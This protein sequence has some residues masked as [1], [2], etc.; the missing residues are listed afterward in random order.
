MAR[1]CALLVGVTLALTACGGAADAPEQEG[2]RGTPEGTARVFS[3]TPRVPLDRPVLRVSSEPSLTIGGGD[4]ESSGVELFRVSDALRLADGRIV[5]ANLGTSEVLVLAPDGRLLRRLGRV[6]G[7]PGEFDANSAIFLAAAGDTLF[8]TDLLR[9][10]FHAFRLDDTTAVPVTVSLAPVPGLP[11]PSVVDRFDDGSWLALAS[12]GGTHGGAPGTV[13]RNTL[14]VLRFGADGAF[15]DTIGTVPV[16]PQI[17]VVH[18]AGT[19]FPLLPLGAEGMA[20]GRGS[21]AVL[22]PGDTALVTTV[23]V[24]TAGRRESSWGRPAVRSADVWPAYREQ[25]RREIA[26]SPSV[27]TRSVY[28]ALYDMD[29]LP[30]PERAA[31]FDEAHVDATGRLW[32]RRVTY[33]D[34]GTDAYRRWDVLAA[35]GTWLGEALVPAGLR[36]LEIGDDWML[37]V[38]YDALDVEWVVLH[39]IREAGAAANGAVGATRR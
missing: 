23:D 31:Q 10:R 39:A 18:G 24:R 17:V 8:A 32:V 4:D 9:Q 37:G 7:G 28:G 26:A 22:L 20:I 14:F 27:R 12:D 3:P 6:G 38:S 11:R 19:S 36:V 35:D 2:A 34:T 33:D 25:R 15:R 29:D 1:A 21:I 5:V 13:I 30:I 16:Q